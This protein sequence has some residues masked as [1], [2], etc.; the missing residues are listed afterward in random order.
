MMA[1]SKN[2]PQ[3]LACRRIQAYRA[4]AVDDES[5]S[6]YPKKDCKKIKKLFHTTS[7]AHYTCD[8]R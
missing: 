4:K 5:P 3:K 1:M 8:T 2:S 6:A 7:I